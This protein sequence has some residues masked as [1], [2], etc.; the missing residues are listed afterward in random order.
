[1]KISSVFVIPPEL[2]EEVDPRTIEETKPYYEGMST[3]DLIRNLIARLYCLN[4][5]ITLKDKIGVVDNFV[6]VM[7]IRDL[8]IPST[9]AYRIIS[10]FEQYTKWYLYTLIW[11]LEPEKT[12]PEIREKIVTEYQVQIAPYIQRYPDYRWV[13]MAIG[14]LLL[15]V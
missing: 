14:S 7:A 13:A 2:D 5:A 10:G 3:L 11:G 9:E 6:H 4:K 1:M 8:L 12:P 15:V